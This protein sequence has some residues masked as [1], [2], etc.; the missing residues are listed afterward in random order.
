MALPKLYEEVT[1][2]SYSEIRYVDGRP[3]GYG[4]GS[5]FAMG[6]NTLVSRPF[7]E[8]VQKFRVVGEWREHDLEDY[9]KGRV[10]DDSML[11]S[12]VL[13]AAL[14][15][16]KNL[17]SFAWELNT[18]P[19]QTVYQSI[20]ARSNLTSFTLRQPTRR[21][22]RPTVLIPP[23]PN[24][25]TLVVYDIDP[26]CYPDDFS[27]VLLT[28]KKLENIKLHWNPRM[29]EVGEES[30][31]L[32]NYFGRCMAAKYKIPA[33]RVA[34]YN[35]YA[36]NTGEGFEECID[37]AIADEITLINS[38]G[39]NDPMTVFLDNTWRIKKPRRIPDRLKM[40]RWDHLDKDHV[41]MLSKFTTL[42]RMYLVRRT[43]ISK[44][45]SMAATPTSPSS[46]TTPSTGPR[47][48]GHQMKS[49]AGDYLAV[50]QAN[51]RNMRHLL[52]CDRWTLNSDAL[53]GL[54]AA[55]PKLEQLGF[56]SE[57]QAMESLRQAIS[58]VPNLWAIRVLIQSDSEQAETLGKM[59]SE[60]HQFALATELWRPEYRNLKYFGLG[61]NLIF[62]LGGVI[63]PAGVR[64]ESQPRTPFDSLENDGL[65]GG[66]VGVNG[67]GHGNVMEDHNP[68]SVRA[69]MRGPM[70]AIKMVDIKDV[71]HIEIWGMDTP[72]FDPKFP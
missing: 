34:F 70:R 63:P 72:E 27:L 12:V 35:M 43:P 54:C 59:G 45:S 51:H 37:P 15:K 61:D 5:P 14:D 38:I 28:S 42:E 13:R 53:I 32:M 40:M 3:E 24:L 44:P 30:V 47:P 60:M 65:A 36:R 1:L 23:L 31:N 66:A 18:K 26:L 21:I 49:L 11:L 56:A 2:R 46:G 55:C 25:K 39:S 69:K 7:A 50:I 20:M 16:M 41:D 4:N 19:M 71:Q 48:E 9:S 58:L 67:N 64:K 57:V 52:L 10:P 6:L 62:K 33:K 29:R 8:Y 68:N 22:P 17:Q